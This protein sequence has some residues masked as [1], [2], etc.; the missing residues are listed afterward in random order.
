MAFVSWINLPSFIMFQTDLKPGNENKHWPGFWVCVC[1]LYDCFYLC[2]VSHMTAHGVSGDH[3]TPV[4][5][6]CD[7]VAVVNYVRMSMFWTVRK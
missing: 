4:A 3:I 5:S 6:C 7:Q 1:D 2:A